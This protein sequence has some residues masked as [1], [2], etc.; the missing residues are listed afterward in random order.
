MRVVK[1]RDGIFQTG[2]GIPF[3]KKKNLF[4]ANSPHILSVTYVFFGPLSWSPICRQGRSCCSVVPKTDFCSRHPPKVP[5]PPPSAPALPFFARGKAFAFARLRSPL[6]LLGKNPLKQSGGKNQSSIDPNCDRTSATRLF[7]TIP[8][9]I[10]CSESR[11]HSK[12]F[13]NI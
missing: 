13:A 7:C 6:P 9:N 10:T 3:F 8:R 5:F 4:W 2:N 1:L 12:Y 11:W